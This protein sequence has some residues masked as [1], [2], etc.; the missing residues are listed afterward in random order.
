MTAPISREEWERQRLAA[1]E[2]LPDVI[3]QV[4][5][6]AVLLPYQANVISLLDSTAIPTPVLIV[7]KSRR[8]GLTWGLAAY[9]V[10]RAGR[11][12]A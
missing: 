4:G 11:E 6:P 5:L 2:A 7:E 3:D 9:A 1:T 12:K 10:L 8:I